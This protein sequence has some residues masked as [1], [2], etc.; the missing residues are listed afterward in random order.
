[1]MDNTLKEIFTQVEKYVS[2]LITNEQSTSFS[3]EECT[4]LALQHLNRLNQRIGMIAR[5]SKNNIDEMRA[6]Q[7]FVNSITIGVKNGNVPQLRYGLTQA[8]NMITSLSEES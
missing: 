1:M 5:S 6:L 7:T 3:K 4:I 8:R 2:P